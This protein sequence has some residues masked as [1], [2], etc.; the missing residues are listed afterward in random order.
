M[1]MLIPAGHGTAWRAPK[2]SG[3]ELMHGVTTS[4]GPAPAGRSAA[5]VRF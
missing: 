4:A 1:E 3:E 5:E 2:T